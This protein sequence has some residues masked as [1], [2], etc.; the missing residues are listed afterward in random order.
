MGHRSYIHHHRHHRRTLLRTSRNAHRRIG[1]RA[2]KE[3]ILVASSTAI[4]LFVVIIHGRRR[5]PGESI[6]V[7]VRSNLLLDGSI[8]GVFRPTFI[9]GCANGEFIG[10]FGES[11]VRERLAIPIDRFPWSTYVLNERSEKLID[12]DEFVES[13]VRSQS[14]AIEIPRERACKSRSDKFASSWE[15]LE[16]PS[17][18]TNIPVLVARVARAIELFYELILSSILSSLPSEPSISSIVKSTRQR[19]REICQ[20]AGLIDFK[21]HPLN[22]AKRVVVCHQRRNIRTRSTRVQSIANSDCW[23]YSDYVCALTVSI[24]PGESNG[25]TVNQLLRSAI[26]ER[27][28]FHKTIQ[29]SFS[30][31]GFL[32]YASGPFQAAAMTFGRGI[33]FRWRKKLSFPFS[34]IV[35]RSIVG[36]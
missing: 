2:D 29:L 14:G 21:E 34:T 30:T 19:D 13:C 10:E 4:T 32:T 3:R 7:A 18:S 33:S 6:S 11:R 28:N 15:E 22:V 8:I 1:R 23:D 26:H 12:D 20:F 5:R 36:W 17:G 24:L 25:E 9:L 16:R 31:R 35:H 27:I